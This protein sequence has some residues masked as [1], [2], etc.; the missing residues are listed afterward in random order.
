MTDMPEIPL[1]DEHGTENHGNVASHVALTG[2]TSAI[3]DAYEAGD[4]DF[5]GTKEFD[6]RTGYRSKSFLTLP[7]KNSEG[8]GRSHRSRP[9]AAFPGGGYSHPLRRAFS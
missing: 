6:E 9:V 7:M 5:F 8:D 2:E 1:H 4:F 3:G